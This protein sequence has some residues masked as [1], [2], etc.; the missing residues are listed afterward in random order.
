M[1]VFSP[2]FLSLLLS[3][4]LLLISIHCSIIATVE[5]GLRVPYRA[6]WGSVLRLIGCLFRAL[7]ENSAA[8]MPGVVQTLAQLYRVRVITTSH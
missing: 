4:F 5:S 8:L 1:S 6:A 2:P 7:G 3:A